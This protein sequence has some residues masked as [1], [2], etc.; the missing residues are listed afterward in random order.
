LDATNGLQILAGGSGVTPTRA[1][2]INNA[3]TIAGW[4]TVSVPPFAPVHA[5]VLKNNTY[6]DLGTLDNTVPSLMSFAWRISEDGHVVGYGETPSNNASKPIH[7]FVW[8]DANNNNTNDAGEM[9][10]P[11]HAEWNKRVRL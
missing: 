3:G 9:K 10:G 1:Q 8:F 11:R 6:I 2:G 7:P 5:F 4:A